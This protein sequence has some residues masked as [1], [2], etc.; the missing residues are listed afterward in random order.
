MTYANGDTYEGN[1]RF[2]SKHGEGMRINIDGSSYEG[3][4]AYDKPNG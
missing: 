4:Y 3:E 1:F 2:G